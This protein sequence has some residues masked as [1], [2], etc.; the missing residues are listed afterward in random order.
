ME[1][2]K[3]GIREFRSGLAEYIASHTPVA[4]TRHGQTVGIFIPTPRPSQADLQAFAKASEAL[5]KVLAQ[6]PP[7]DIEQ[8]MIEFKALRKAGKIDTATDR[9][10]APK[11]RVRA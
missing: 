9:G 7:L 3:V 4:V 1:P 5:D 11:K 10:A 8:V 6:H 2:T